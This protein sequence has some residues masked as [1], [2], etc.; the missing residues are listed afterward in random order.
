M[1]LAVFRTLRHHWVVLSLDAAC[2]LSYRTRRAL[3][4]PPNV[5][6]DPA[7]E[8]CTC[9]YTVVVLATLTRKGPTGNEG[10]APATN[11]NG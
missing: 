3:R 9:K 4:V 10:F 2:L 6:V 5:I 7:N 8:A 11:E 1:S